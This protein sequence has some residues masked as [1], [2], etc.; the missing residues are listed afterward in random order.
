MLFKEIYYSSLTR[1]TIYCKP[2]D[3]K[4]LKRT[5]AQTAGTKLLKTKGI[6]II[7]KSIVEKWVFSR[8]ASY[9]FP[10]SYQRIHINVLKSK[11]LSNKLF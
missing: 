10:Y 9:Y 11:V 5:L 8:S 6:I 7:K 3:I 1:N 4:E 2:L